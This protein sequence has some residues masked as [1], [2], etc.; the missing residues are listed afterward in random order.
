MAKD[1]VT[2]KD[3]DKLL[4]LLTQAVEEMKTFPEVFNKDTCEEW[5]KR[6]NLFGEKLKRYYSF[7]IHIQ[8][9]LGIE[10]LPEDEP[11]AVWRKDV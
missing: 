4:R 8:K 2:D 1:T 9:R 3:W 11:E 5:K 7:F 6:M 10:V